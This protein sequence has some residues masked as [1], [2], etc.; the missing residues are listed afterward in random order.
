MTIEYSSFRSN[1]PGNNKS[2][3]PIIKLMIWKLKLNQKLS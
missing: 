3:K 2:L 1:N